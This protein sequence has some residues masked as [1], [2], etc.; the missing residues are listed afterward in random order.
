MKCPKCGLEQGDFKSECMRCGLI[1][2]RYRPPEEREFKYPLEGMPRPPLPR[3][4]LNYLL[5][6]KDRIQPVYFAGRVI[7]FAAILLWSLKFFE[8]S[9]ESNYV[10]HSFMHLVNLPFHEA[11]HI[12]FSIF[13]R[14]MHSLG[15]TLGQIIMPVACTLVLLIKT[16]DTFGASMTLWWTGESL[17]DM[18]P[19]INDAR[20]MSLQ[21]L[22]G[23]TG[24]SAPYGFHDWNYLLTEMNILDHE[25]TL[26]R[27]VE[28]GGKAV[29]ALALLW[30]LV[31]LLKQ[32]RRLKGFGKK[33]ALSG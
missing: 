3:R 25:R 4:M 21:L 18:A 16:R 12:V 29:M 2:S 1:F 33:R 7:V 26:A 15:G 30:G 31:V 32:M 9:I 22:G 10:G 5:F 28:A 24:A 20:T 13:G 14:F 27:L 8:A 6:T 11:G 23:N 19:Y 17:L